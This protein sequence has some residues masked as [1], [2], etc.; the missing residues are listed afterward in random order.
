MMVAFWR[1]IN[2][3]GGDERVMISSLMGRMVL[4]LLRGQ[5][6]VLTLEAT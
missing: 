5:S 2:E 3:R 4:T 1:M 6:I